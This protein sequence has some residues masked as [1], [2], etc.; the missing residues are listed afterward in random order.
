MHGQAGE[1]RQDRKVATVTTFSQCRGLPGHLFL[2]D[3]NQAGSRTNFRP[4]AK[5]EPPST[6][7]ETRDEAAAGILR[8]VGD[9]TYRAAGRFRTNFETQAGFFSSSAIQSFSFSH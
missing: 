2:Q 6:V 3:V 9:P 1:P 8:R 5:F 7:R 4:D